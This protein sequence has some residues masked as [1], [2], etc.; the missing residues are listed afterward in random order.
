MFSNIGLDGILSC[1][2]VRKHVSGKMQDERAGVERESSYN[3]WTKLI[4][5]RGI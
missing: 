2:F 5:K 4:T 1:S 3:F